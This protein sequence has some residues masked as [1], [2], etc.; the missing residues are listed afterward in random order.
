MTIQ[1]Y[2]GKFQQDVFDTGEVNVMI[3]DRVEE[4]LMDIF[5]EGDTGQGISADTFYT[6][7][8]LDTKLN[9]YLTKLSASSTYATK[10]SLAD[11]LTKSD[12]SFT[13]ATESDVASALQTLNQNVQNDYLTKS[14]ASSTYAAKHH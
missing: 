8:Q 6:R 4:V 3:S 13:Y 10:T 1:N 2:I 12:A 11:Y 7:S 5:S 9:D 14:D